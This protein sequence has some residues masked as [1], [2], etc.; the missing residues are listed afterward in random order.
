MTELS[1]CKFQMN[2]LY[3]LRKFIYS[4]TIKSLEYKQQNWYVKVIVKMWSFGD[5]WIL[6]K[7]FKW[8]SV[9]KFYKPI[10]VTAS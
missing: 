9:C 4:L 2:Y 8:V 1:K 10:M 7:E 5:I 6:H 3:W